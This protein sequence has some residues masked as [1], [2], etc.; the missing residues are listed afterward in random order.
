MTTGVFTKPSVKGVPVPFRPQ[1]YDDCIAV[2]LEPK[3]KQITKF[4]GRDR[5]EIV[6]TLTVFETQEDIDNNDPA[7]VI[8][9]VVTWG[10]IA[11]LLN[12]ALVDGT[13]VA[14]RIGQDPPTPHGTRPWRLNDLDS[15]TETCLAKWLKA[16]NSKG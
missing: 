3:A 1:D 13:P 6:A 2:V 12:R 4:N 5:L 7:E 8:E 15:E 9:M 10:R 11:S 16:R 14:A